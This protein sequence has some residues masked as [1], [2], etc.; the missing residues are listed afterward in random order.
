MLRETT[1]E[2]E[3]W[4][5]C[6]KI[7]LSIRFTVLLYIEFLNR[8]MT[9]GNV[10][11]KI[12]SFDNNELIADGGDWN[13]ALNPTLDTN[14]PSS[15]YRNR[16]RGRIQEFIE[17]CDVVDIFRSLYHNIRKYTWR[18]FNSTQRSRLDYFVVSEQLG[19]VTESV[20]R[21][22]VQTTRLCA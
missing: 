14:H 10:F 8:S 4:L 2:A 7:T 11:N 13:V 19:C 17:Q 21:V 18:R 5:Y 9:L 20:L 12:T 3:W 15:I 22:T 6:L 16:S 1:L